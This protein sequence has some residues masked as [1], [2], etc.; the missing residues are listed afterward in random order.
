VSTN[1]FSLRLL[2]IAEQ[3]F[4]DIIEYVA[5]ENLTA[6]HRIAD[7]SEQDLQRLQR[8]PYLGESSRRH[9]AGKDEVSSTGRR[10]LPNLL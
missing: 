3:D 5:A 10:L 4:I 8:H 7:H 9:Q 2:S 6:A 1:R